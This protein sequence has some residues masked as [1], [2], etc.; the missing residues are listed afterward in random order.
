M[1]MSLRQTEPHCLHRTPA[2]GL[3]EQRRCPVQCAGERAGLL[4]V[5]REERRGHIWQAARLA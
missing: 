1:D 4:T 3:I 5:Y 2:T